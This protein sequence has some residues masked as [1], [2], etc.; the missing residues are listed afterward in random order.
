MIFKEY[1]MLS[2]MPHM[3][4]DYELEQF[5][6]AL[7]EN[8]G[9]APEQLLKLFE[10]FM[11]K[12]AHNE[13]VLTRKNHADVQITPEENSNFIEDITSDAFLG[14]FYNGVK[15]GYVK[16]PE[17][18]SKSRIYSKLSIEDRKKIKNYMLS[19]VGGNIVGM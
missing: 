7:P 16:F 2:E 3:Q 18:V 12:L 6:P 19:L 14:Y 13:H 8:Q 15:L 10:D 4:I 1:Y 17:L 9:L 11:R 5:S